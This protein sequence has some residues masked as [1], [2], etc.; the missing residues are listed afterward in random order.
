M[1]GVGGALGTAGSTGA[2]ALGVVD[3]EREGYAGGYSVAGVSSPLRWRVWVGTNGTDAT[4][5]KGGRAAADELPR[6][7]RGSSGW[8]EKEPVRGRD[9][10]S[11]SAGGTTEGMDPRGGG[12][13][14]AS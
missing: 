10:R 1:Y 4:E 6:R 7:R 11:A 8:A 14:T 13:G 5:R 12:I 2:Y 9:V 3:V